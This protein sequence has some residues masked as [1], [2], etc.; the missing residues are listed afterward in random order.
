MSGFRMPA[1]AMERGNA[2]TADSAPR[3]VSASE[4]IAT[5]VIVL[6]SFIPEDARPPFQPQ[7]RTSRQSPLSA[8]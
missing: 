5:Y 4:L 8:E 7:A 1:E 2:V 3:A 6:C